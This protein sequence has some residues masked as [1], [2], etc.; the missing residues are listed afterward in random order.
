MQT[1]Y[2]LKQTKLANYHAGLDY[3]SEVFTHDPNSMEKPD[4]K[5]LEGNKKLANLV[6]EEYFD[7]GELNPKEESTEIMKPVEA[8]TQAPFVLR[9]SSYQK[10]FIIPY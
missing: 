9:Q 8:A 7:K 1:L 4:F 10:I 2:A 5:K 3:I 6:F